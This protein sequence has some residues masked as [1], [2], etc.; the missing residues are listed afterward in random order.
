MTRRDSIGTAAAAPIL[1]AN[2][3]EAAGLINT[4]VKESRF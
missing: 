4:R 2:D 3:N 1:S